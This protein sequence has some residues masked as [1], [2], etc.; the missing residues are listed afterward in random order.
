MTQTPQHDLLDDGQVPKS[1][2]PE[3][4]RGRIG[5]ARRDGG[6][7]RLVD[8]E[9]ARRLVQEAR[10][11]GLDIAGPSGLLQQMMKSV[12]EAALAEELTDHLGYEAGDPSGRGTGNSRNGSTAK[13][14]LTESA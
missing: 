5:R 13:T 1:E 6:E 3:R 12:L 2:P 10:E 14:L 11:Q 8:P 4:P 7:P 9:V